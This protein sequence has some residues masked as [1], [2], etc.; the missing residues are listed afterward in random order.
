MRTL[1]PQLIVSTVFA[2]QFKTPGMSKLGH[3]LGPGVISE[4]SGSVIVYLV[5]IITEF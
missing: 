4:L 1:F 2:K 3:A 5:K